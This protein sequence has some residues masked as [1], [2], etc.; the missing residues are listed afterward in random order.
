MKQCSGNVVVP[1]AFQASRLHAPALATTND[2]EF[3][4]QSATA[5]P[6]PHGS[7]NGGGIDGDAGYLSL[8]K[9]GVD[10]ELVSFRNGTHLTYTYVPYILPSNELS[11]RFA[12][13]YTLAWFDE[14]LRG[15]RDPYTPQSAYSRLTSLGKYDASPDVNSK[16]KVSIG[17]GTYDPNAAAADPTN[18][19][20]GNVPYLIKGIS[21]PDSLSFYYYSEFSL[22]NPATEQKRT[23]TD[24]LAHCPAKPPAIP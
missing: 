18:P 2:Y 15:G 17:A 6:N 1:K 22:T 9:S 16:G 23:C 21:I 24:M 3:N 7:T 12:F 10:S 11:E 4:V 8:A 13:Y 19:E 5:P 20:A 14:Y